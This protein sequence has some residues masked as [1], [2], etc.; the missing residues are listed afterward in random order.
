MG[1]QDV[2]TSER[3]KKVFSSVCNRQLDFAL[4]FCCKIP[5]RF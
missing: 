2:E 1:L 3:K 4:L 5:V